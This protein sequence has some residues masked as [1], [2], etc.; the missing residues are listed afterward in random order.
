MRDPSR[1]DSIIETLRT[2]WKANPDQRLCQL[3]VN[4]ADHGNDPFYVE[5]DRFLERL[6]QM[7]STARSSE[8][9]VAC[10]PACAGCVSSGQCDG[11]GGCS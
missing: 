6:L 10:N 11:F 7:T 4:V 2:V 5:D 3:V 9:V 1:I 8:V